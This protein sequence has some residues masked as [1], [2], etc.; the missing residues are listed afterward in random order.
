MGFISFISDLL[1]R[2]GLHRFKRW[3]RLAGFTPDIIEFRQCRWC[4]KKWKKCHVEFEFRVNSI[5][6]ELKQP[7]SKWKW[8][9][10]KPS[11]EDIREKR[12]RKLGI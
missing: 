5:T 1:C 6:G 7:H 12:L 3:K 8:I 4:L 9:V 11:R 2:C 10:V